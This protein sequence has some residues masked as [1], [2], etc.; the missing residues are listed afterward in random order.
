MN[1]KHHF[2]GISV[3]LTV[4]AGSI[5]KY[6]NGNNP[7]PLYCRQLSHE[8]REYLSAYI[9]YARRYTK[10]NFK[11]FCGDSTNMRFQVEPPMKTI[12]RHYSIKKELKEAEFRKFKKKNYLLLFISIGIVMFCQGLLPEIFNQEHRI[13]SMLG[14]TLDVF[15]W[16]VMWKPIERLIF[17]WNPYL[18]E[19]ILFDKMIRDEVILIDN[20]QELI[21]HHMEHVDAA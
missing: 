2:K 18:K 16:V 15:S 21:N 5:H 4:N 19:I 3:Y 10:I 20:E 11:I 12:R 13:H 17:Y 8:F 7:A 1:A 9:S 14:N 6:Y